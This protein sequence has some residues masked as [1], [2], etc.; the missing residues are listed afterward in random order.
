MLSFLRRGLGGARWLRRP[1]TLGREQTAHFPIMG[2]AQ[3]DLPW[4]IKSNPHLGKV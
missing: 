2:F 4:N 3:W 1:W